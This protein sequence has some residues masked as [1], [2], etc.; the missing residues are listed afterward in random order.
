RLKMWSFIIV[1]CS[2]QVI[3]GSEPFKLPSNI[4][5]VFPIQKEII[6][7]HGYPCEE[8]QVESEDGYILTIFRIP[9]GREN[10]TNK[11]PRPAVFLQHAFLG[12]STHWISNL[13]NN[14]FGF[15]LADAGYDVWIAN[16]RGN[17][18][19]SKHKTLTTS[20][21]EFWEFSF[22]EF[23]YYD[24][25]ALIYF[26]LNK[27]NQ[28]QLYFV[29]H[30]E[31]SAAGFIAFSSWPKL[32][33]RIKVFFA[34]GPVTTLTFAT[35]AGRLIFS[36]TFSNTVSTFFPLQQY[37]L[38]TT[39][40]V[41]FQS[42]LDVYVAQ[43]P[44]GTSMQNLL[45]WSQVYYLLFTLSNALSLLFYSQTTPPVYRIEDIKIP[46]SV[47]TGGQD[48]FADSRDVGALCFRISNL[49]DK[50]HIPEWQ[51]VDFIWGLDATER[52]YRHI[53]ETMRKYP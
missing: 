31:G 39:I 36:K 9:H 6:L 37:K 47:W 2:F 8:Y 51:H 13:P 50:R 32:A 44:A 7:H 19:S 38:F 25:P 48:L 46:I 23:G 18:W 30:S 28:E 3:L 43:S 41:L 24:I 5:N 29:G 12:V 26:I 45:H 4:P 11:G 42:R 15:I 53:I 21:K 1:A 35:T 49:I 20:E 10:D 40:A 27:T 14:S 22:H 34:L 16:S 33:E 52:M 17:M